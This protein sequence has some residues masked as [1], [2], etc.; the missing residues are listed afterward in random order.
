MDSLTP[1]KSSWNVVGLLLRGRLAF[2]RMYARLQNPLQLLQRV[3]AL[4]D[5]LPRVQEEWQKVMVAKQTIIDLARQQQ[6]SNRRTLKQ[7]S[8]AADIEAVG[9]DEPFN[10]FRSIHEGWEKENRSRVEMMQVE[11]HGHTLLASEELNIEVMRTAGTTRGRDEEDK[12]ETVEEEEVGGGAESVGE[13]EQGDGSREPAHVISDE[14]FTSVSNIV[15]GRCKREECNELLELII[16]NAK[17]ARGAPLTTAKLV[18]LGARV[19]GQTGGCRIATLR[20]LKRITIS[21]DGVVLNPKYL[22]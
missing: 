5:D 21:K 16:R 13:E 14:E 7:L 17:K 6:M 8:L 11:L 18:E 4:Q 22:K 1:E 12:E 9:R 10:R 19:T 2:S 20:S 3:K 15:R